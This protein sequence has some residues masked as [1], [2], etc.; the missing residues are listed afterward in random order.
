M[1][2]ILTRNLGR[3]AVLSLEGRIVVGETDALR[4][5]VLAQAEASVVVLDLAKVNT[6][7]ARGLGA[8]LELREQTQAKGIEF[9]LKN[10]TSLVGRVLEITRLDSIFPVSYANEPLPKATLQIPGVR[11]RNPRLGASA[12]R[13]N[14]SQL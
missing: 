2:K 6:I 7:D 1:L 13:L 5:A 9:R 11:T 10:V 4:R 8:L 12:C 3:V 14:T